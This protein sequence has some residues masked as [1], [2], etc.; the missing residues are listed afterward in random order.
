MP[1]FE[2]EK[3]RLASIEK[4]CL[5]LILILSLVGAV[6]YSH[7]VFWGIVLGGAVSLLNIR[8]LI[9]IVEVIFSQH[10]G[11]KLLVVAQYIIK[12]LLLFGLVYFLVSK[13]VVSI[14]AFL[15]GFSIL[16]FA[17]MLECLF[18]FRP[19]SDQEE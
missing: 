12:V 1:G 18:P 9:R 10:G 7:K 17:A 19:R 5:I 14:L 11:A 6:W 13:Q 2:Q 15:L 8:V 4:K 16:L 3:K